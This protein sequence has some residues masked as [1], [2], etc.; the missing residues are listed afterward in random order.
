L[1]RPE[2]RHLRQ[3]N[4]Q[5]QQDQP[6]RLDLQARECLRMMQVPGQLQQ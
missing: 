4:Q 5:D 3:Q 1:Q 6:D 2:L